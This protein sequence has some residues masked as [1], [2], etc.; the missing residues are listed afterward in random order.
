MMI[1]RPTAGIPAYVGFEPRLTK[2]SDKES[3]LPDKQLKNLGMSKESQ[4]DKVVKLV[5]S[6]RSSE[7]IAESYPKKEEIEERARDKKLRFRPGPV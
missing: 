1:N 7:G 2:K 6:E 5:E 3:T 4:Y